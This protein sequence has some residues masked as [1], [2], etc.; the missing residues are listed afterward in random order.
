MSNSAL[1]TTAIV[2]C[3]VAVAAA[4]GYVAWDNV[5]S[6]RPSQAQSRI[7]DR[8]ANI[9]DNNGDGRVSYQEIRNVVPE[10]SSSR[11]QIM[12]RFRQMDGNYDGYLTAGDVGSK[13]KIF[14]RYLD[15][16]RSGHID[17]AELYNVGTLFE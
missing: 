5:S 15:D 11:A 13:Y 8:V 6:S 7:F 4:A 1:T 3:A 17:S 2:C 12:V 16:D 14:L 10:S 9:Y